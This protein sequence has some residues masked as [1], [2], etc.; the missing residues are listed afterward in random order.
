LKFLHRASPA[1]PVTQIVLIFPRTGVCLD[2]PDRQGLTRLASRMLFTGAAG[3]GH[4]EYNSRLERLGAGAG[5]GLSSDHV[6]MRLTTLTQNL[7]AALDLLVAAIEKPN[8]DGDEFRRLRDEL[9]SSWISDRE[10][11]TNLRAQD[12]YIR[13]LYA[14]AP[15][16]Y[17]ADGTAEGLLGATVD[18]VRKHVP[19]LFG[20]AE[21]ILGVLSDLPAEEAERRIVPR[22][23]GLRRGAGKAD[24]PWDGFHP[25]RPKGRTATI[26]ADPATQTDELIAGV[27]SVGEAD[28]DWHVHRLIALIFGGD[29]NSR[30]FRVIRGEHGFSYGASCWYESSHGRSPRNQVS[31]FT[32]YTFPTVEHTAAALPMLVRLYEDLVARGVEKDELERAKEALIHSHAFLRDTPQKQLFLDCDEALYGI[33]IDDNAANRKKIAAVTPEDVLRVLKATH[34]PESLTF[35]LLG[36][37]ARLEA[38]AKSIP[39]L[40]GIE[41]IEYPRRRSAA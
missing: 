41:L 40:D 6:T 38:A 20:D 1:F 14:D 4:S 19:N 35:T 34:H 5:S 13:T 18:D 30:L 24:Y 3:M 23:A 36:D 2:P 21:P 25:E 16:G 31:P 12:V 28:P 37:A 10:E 8:L 32:L 26:I 33:P 39:G 29:M 9:H 22:L 17:Q 11:H 15:T 7:D 27:F